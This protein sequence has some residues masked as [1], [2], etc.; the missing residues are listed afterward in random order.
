MDSFPTRGP[1]LFFLHSAARTPPST[2]LLSTNTPS[3]AFSVLFPRASW[4]LLQ[5]RC[6]LCPGALSPTNRRSSG[7]G[8]RAA[9]L[10]ARYYLASSSRSTNLPSSKGLLPHVR[11]P[12]NPYAKAFSTTKDTCAIP[13]SSLLPTH[14]TTRPTGSGF[15]RLDSLEVIDLH[16]KLGT[17]FNPPAT[18]IDLGLHLSHRTSPP[19]RLP[20]RPKPLTRR[21]TS[22]LSRFQH[23]RHSTTPRDHLPT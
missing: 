23:G 19:L 20:S 15:G 1:Q 17:A 18:T 21:A 7:Q 2:G 5:A 10:F 3:T 12:E 8:D 13:N 16:D 6:L 4:P 9:Q 22:P 11:R 14:S